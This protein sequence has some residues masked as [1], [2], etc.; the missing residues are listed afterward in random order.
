[1]TDNPWV[2]DVSRDWV[3]ACDVQQGFMQS[4]VQ[5][6]DLWDFSA[7]CRQV[8]ELGGDCFDFTPLEDHR[9]ALTIGDASGKSLPAALMITGV[10]LSLRTA[11]SIIGSDLAAVVA[12][13]N[14][15]AHATSP[16]HRYT[17][18]FYAVF[19][20]T[21]RVLRYVN[22]GHHPPMV[23]RRDNSI[24]RLEAGGLPVGL[25]PDS[26]YH[27]GAVRLDQ[28]DLVLA[29]TDGVTE[30]TNP[31]GEEWGV[32]GLHKVAAENSA[33]PTPDIVDEIFNRMDEFSHGSQADDA[34]V[35]VLRVP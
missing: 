24:L 30:A 32:Q 12:G 28:G 35:A 19:D 7:R 5:A 21:T 29:Y 8:L 22:A 15:Q 14:R 16:A 4:N 6:A 23:V 18:L 33:R 3:A 17:T 10:Q 26:A 9:L 27:E 1:M 31:A 11:A 13:V 34:T 25:L 20:A 2:L